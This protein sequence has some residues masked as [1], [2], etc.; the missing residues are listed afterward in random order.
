MLG[1]TA[2]T[3]S[4]DH[5]GRSPANPDHSLTLPGLSHSFS[6]LQQLRTPADSPV[7]TL[8]RSIPLSPF[9]LVLS[10]YSN[11]DSG[12]FPVVTVKCSFTLH[13]PFTFSV[14]SLCFPRV[15]SGLLASPLLIVPL[16]RI[17]SSCDV[18]AFT[19]FITLIYFL[20]TPQ[21]PCFVVYKYSPPVC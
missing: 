13:L 10:F 15:R 7:N 6:S 21:F 17:C 16:S 19:R 3:P 5:S 2:L 9:I 1:P 18:S 8:T 20:G 14:I 12:P 4:L 11:S